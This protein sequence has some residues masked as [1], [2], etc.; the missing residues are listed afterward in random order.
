MISADKQKATMDL[1]PFDFSEV[2]N[3]ARSAG[4]IGHFKEIHVG[5]GADSWHVDK[6]GIFMG[7]DTRATATMRWRF[8]GTRLVYDGTT[9]RVIEGVVD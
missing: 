8:D 4:D 3:D 1:Q 6:D 2:G 9:D 5:E 7:G